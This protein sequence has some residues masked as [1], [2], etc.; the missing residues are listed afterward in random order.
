MNAGTYD[1]AALGHVM[2]D[3]GC[4]AIAAACV[5]GAILN[6]AGKEAKL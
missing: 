6:L 3:R 4:V 5:L 1:I 2:V